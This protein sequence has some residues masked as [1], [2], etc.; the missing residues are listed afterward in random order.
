MFAKKRRLELRGWIKTFGALT[1]W[2]GWTWELKSFFSKRGFWLDGILYH[3][4]WGNQANHHICGPFKTS[5]LPGPSS[6]WPW[7]SIQPQC[8]GLHALHPP[9]VGQHPND[10]LRYWFPRFPVPPC[11]RRRWV[12]WWWRNGPNMDYARRRAHSGGTKGEKKK[13]WRF[14]PTFGRKKWGK[15]LGEHVI[16]TSNFLPVLEGEKAGFL[17]L[18]RCFRVLPAGKLVEENMKLTFP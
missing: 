4:S 15:H 7:L 13:M 18:N 14:F 11:W 6:S 12:G 16:L 5:S 1:C 10:A 8:Q 2:R 3:L 9:G 17:F